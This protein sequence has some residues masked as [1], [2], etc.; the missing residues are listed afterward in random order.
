MTGRDIQELKI[1]LIA[2]DFGSV[3]NLEAH[4][5]EDSVDFTQDAR[6]GVNLAQRLRATGQADIDTVFVARRFQFRQFQ[7]GLALF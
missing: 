5:A 2:L 1:I 6:G 3:V 4:R 7:R